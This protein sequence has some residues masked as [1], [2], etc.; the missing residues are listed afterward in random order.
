MQMVP[1]AQQLPIFIFEEGL[2][3]TVLLAF[4]PED[5]RVLTSILLRRR[6]LQ[7]QQGLVRNFDDKTHSILSLAI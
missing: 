6:V 4:Q 7:S 5:Y 1:S 3:P 2:F